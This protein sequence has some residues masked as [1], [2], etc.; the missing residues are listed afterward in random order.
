MDYMQHLLNNDDFTRGLGVQGGYA[1]TIDIGDQFIAMS[2]D[3]LGTK[4]MLAK[5]YFDYNR[6]GQDLVASVVNDVLC[7]GAA[8]KAFLD[9]VALGTF[10]LKFLEHFI[11]GV[12]LGCRMSH[13]ELVGGET[14]EMNGVYPAG[15]FDLAGFAVGIGTRKI[16]P[17]L[18]K[19]G[20]PIIGLAS[21]GIHAN[22]FT[23][24]RSLLEKT[25]SP[26]E[27]DLLAPTYNYTMP[28]TV[29]GDSIQSLAH[30][31]G[32]GI[33]RALD[34]LL[35]DETY[36]DIDESLLCHNKASKWLESQ[37]YQP[38]HQMDVFNCGFGMVAVVNDVDEIT[39]PHT[40]LGTVKEA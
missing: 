22:G 36:A 8:P 14:A 17:H 5:N 30:V 33:N 25:M 1:P 19:P 15:K 12:K 9:Y 31:S 11:M 6:L 32:G 23:V 3:G 39:I 2:T 18:V 29:M 34:R 7:T 13:C 37:G 26:L 40:H 21:S 24:V 38:E 4:I 16:G 20:M 28:V 27:F 35:P 10:D